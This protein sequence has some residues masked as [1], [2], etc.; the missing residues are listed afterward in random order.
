MYLEFGFRLYITSLSHNVENNH[1]SQRVPSKPPNH[2][3]HLQYLEMRT[4]WISS[5]EGIQAE[6]VSRKQK[7][8]KA[9]QRI[10][11]LVKV[12][13]DMPKARF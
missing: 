10:I 1:L 3:V 8:Q 2:T 6:C 7:Q 11:T 5:G 13:C 9:I 4:N 12:Q